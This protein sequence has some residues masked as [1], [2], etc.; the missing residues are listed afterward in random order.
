M[1]KSGTFG[2]R[3]FVPSVSGVFKFFILSLIL[4]QITSIVY[5]KLPASVQGHWPRT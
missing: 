5:P 4:H 1:A 2:W 3:S